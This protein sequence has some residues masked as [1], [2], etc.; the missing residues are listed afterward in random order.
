[1]NLGRSSGLFCFAILLSCV[2]LLSYGCKPKTPKPEEITTSEAVVAEA[3]PVEE[4]VAEEK[5]SIAETEPMAFEEMPAETGKTSH[6][7][8]KGECL[9]W[10]AEYEDVY[11]DPFQWPLIYKANR[12]QIKDPDLIYPQQVFD[13]PR[14]S[15]QQEIDAARHEAKTRGPWSLWDGK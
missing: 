12:D 14:D 5:P 10:I 9:W 1:M 6:T 3:E 13:I 2:T 8:K 11:N 4:E 15:S 7:V